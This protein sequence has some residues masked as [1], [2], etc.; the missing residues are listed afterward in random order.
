MENLDNIGAEQLP[1]N[2]E[3][4]KS[5]LG[6][7]L[8]DFEGVVESLERI[9]PEY[10]YSNR[11]KIIFETLFRIYMEGNPITTIS[12][13]EMLESNGNLQRAGGATYIAGL[14]DVSTTS[15]NIDYYIDIVS[16]KAL[17]R[18]IINAGQQIISVG[19][20]KGGETADQILEQAENQVLNIS[21]QRIGS[22]FRKLDTVLDE[23]FPKDGSRKDS[24][25]TAISTGFA[26]LDKLITGFLPGQLI[27][28]AARPSVGKSTLGLDFMRHASIMHKVPSILF[29][30]EMSYQEIV[31]RLMSAESS[32]ELNKIRKNFMNT[33]EKQ[34]FYANVNRVYD[35]P[36][37]IDDSP[38]LNMTHIRSK[39]TR[40]KETNDLKLIVIDYLQLMQSGEKHDNRAAEVGSISRSLKK[41]AKQL[42]VPIIAMAQLNRKSEEGKGRRPMM[43][44]LRE[45]GSIEQ[46]ADVILLIHR[47]DVENKKS[48]RPGEADL[49]VA[50]QRNGATGD[51]KLLFQGSKS[52][53]ASAG[54][55]MA[56][57]VAAGTS[58]GSGENGS[59]AGGSGTV[60]SNNDGGSSSS[61]TNLEG[62]DPRTQEFVTATD[63]TG[64]S[65]ATVA[66]TGAGSNASTDFESGAP[67]PASSMFSDEP[68]TQSIS[69][70]PFATENSM[71]S[72]VASVEDNLIST[73]GIPTVSV[74]DEFDDSDSDFDAYDDDLDED[75]LGLPD[76]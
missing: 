12:V 15:S 2:L 61:G 53:F 59:G 40:L 37:L 74:E 44:D 31:E 51:V 58:G 54:Q 16:E 32:I 65:W 25:A 35:A 69:V 3:A 42:E 49:I 52:R 23:V 27:I 62:M 45:S 70:D 71:A 55:I 6:A 28:V 72:N 11:N 66:N 13:I 47:E 19:H 29:S 34:V 5:I 7:M 33:K 17:R 67:V 60:S 75:F 57:M 50:K 8:L 22:D 18:S 64:A 39:A 4:E 1:N 26:D 76:L 73:E 14:M 46:D 24:T 36:L 41:L 10:F 48:E 30:L 38:E 43:S 68:T 63:S 20:S 9:K 21:N 56:N